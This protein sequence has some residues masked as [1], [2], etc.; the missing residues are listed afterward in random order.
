MQY[1]LPPPSWCRKYEAPPVNASNMHTDL[2]PSKDWNNRK[3]F[4]SG[5]ER[6]NSYHG[7]RKNNKKRCHGY[8]RSFEG[9][10]NLPEWMTHEGVWDMETQDPVREFIRAIALDEGYGT[11]ENTV[12]DELREITRVDSKMK[13]VMVPDWDDGFNLNTDWILNEDLDSRVRSPVE[14]EMYAK[15]EAKFDS[16]IEALWSKDQ[17]NTPDDEYQDLPID[18]QDLLSSPSDQMFYDVAPVEKNLAS[19]TESIWSNDAFDATV[20][21]RADSPTTSADVLHDKLRPLNLADNVRARP[22]SPVYRTEEPFSL[23]NCE[24]VFD[25]VPAVSATTQSLLALNHSRDRSGF[26]EVIP[27]RR[28]GEPAPPPCAPVVR[29]AP[30]PADDPLTSA[31]THFR[32]IRGEA[33]TAEPAAARLA[34]GATFDIRSD[35]DEVVYRRSDSG[36]LYLDGRRYMEYR[37]GDDIDYGRLHLTAEQSEHFDDGRGARLKFAVRGTDVGVQTDDVEE[38]DAAPGGAGAPRA[39]LERDEE[40]GAQRSGRGD[41]KR[42]HSA[43]LRCGRGAPCPHPHAPFLQCCSLDR[44]LTR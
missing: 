17:A 29:P 24:S 7:Q 16:S 28:V 44:P 15:F 43:A 4:S 25:A 6:R 5:K 31:R 2:S 14:E 37:A 1:Y 42:R 12:T 30:A 3:K 8:S 38:V 23:Y 41:R 36:R 27:R 9:K 32:P 22:V 21:R 10:E 13:E 26:A 35:L 19:L 20:G 33:P 34:D 39:D 40:G 18:F 11:C